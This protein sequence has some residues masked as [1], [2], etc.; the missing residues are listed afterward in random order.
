[1]QHKQCLIKLQ[2]QKMQLHKRHV[3]LKKVHKMLGNNSKRV[4]GILQTLPAVHKNSS[5]SYALHEEEDHNKNDVKKNLNHTTM[6]YSTT[7]MI[8]TITTAMIMMIDR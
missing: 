1:M 6:I 2:M 5:Y 3:I 8:M 4:R 7:T